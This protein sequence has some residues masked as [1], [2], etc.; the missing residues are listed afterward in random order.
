MS[1]PVVN[2]SHVQN[3]KQNCETGTANSQ[4]PIQEHLF[5]QSWYAPRIAATFLSDDI[6]S[7]QPIQPE[8]LFEY[9][10]GR[11]LVNEKYEVS[12]RYAK[13]DL[14]ALCAVVSSVPSVSSPISKIDKLEGGFNKAL[15]MTAENGKEL[16][17]KIPCPLV[18]PAEHSTASE[19]ALLEYI[20][21]QTSVPVSKVLAWSS[22]SSNPVGSEYIV[23]EK[24]NGR[25]LVDV[26]GEM[27]QLQQFR[28]IQNLVRLEC[29]LAS[30]EFP[31]Y[32]N[33]YFRR[34]I[35]HGSPVIPINDDY[36]LGPAYNASW[37][38]Q[39]GNQDCAGP[40]STLAKLF[41]ALAHRGLAHV[42]RS[43]LVPRGP[44]FGTRPEHIH[45]LEAAMKIIP[46]FV[47]Y[48]ERFSKPTLWHGD[49]HLGNIFVCSKDPT[50]IVG[51]IDWQFVSIMPAFMQ[52]QWPSFI[53]PPENY[54][55]GVVK[56]NLPPDFDDMDSDEKAFA[57]AERDQAILSKCYEAAL[58]KNCLE[59]YRALT[60]ADTAVQQLLSSTENTWKDG[61]IPL[62]DA[63]VQ[64]S[65]N[66]REL[67]FSGPCPYQISRDDLL[68]HRLEL[69]RYKDWQKLKT[70]TQEL[71]HSDD[72]GWI[73]PQL[74]FSKVQARHNEL[75]RLFKESEELTE[76]EAKELWVYIDRAE[77]PLL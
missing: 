26:W 62:R 27:N 56:P 69:S 71:L 11:F 59:S 76:E 67:G 8:Q 57:V 20:R 51:I 42:Q 21:S 74:N 13:F 4:I 46:R 70:Y 41:L 77:R 7:G 35:K 72:D 52:V 25:Q 75:F 23:M 61:I 40:W 19:A 16:I 58:A 31:G 50:R 45:I 29:Q 33:V 48:I 28:M 24:V 36:C 18:V 5:N 64:I 10:N 63:L 54:E 6:C 32:G 37:F 44:H 60:D 12:K 66:W 17:A 30:L 65:E 14:E 47:G 3:T 15:L 34:S 9:T 22:D 73:S 2:N 38:P 53:S 1:G 49:L 55:I 43:K 68:R 39:T